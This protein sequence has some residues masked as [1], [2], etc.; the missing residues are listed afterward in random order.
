MD[1][2]KRWILSQQDNCDKIITKACNEFWEANKHKPN[3]QYDLEKCHSESYERD[4]G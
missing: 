2:V 3:F 4:M 1:D